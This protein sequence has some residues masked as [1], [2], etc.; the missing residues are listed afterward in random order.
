MTGEDG[1]AVLQRIVKVLLI[2]PFDEDHRDL[3]E[4]LRHSN[5]QQY[6]ARTQVEACEFLRENVTPG[7]YLRERTAGRYLAECLV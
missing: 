2:S 3:R 6:E 7:G 1:P 5:W 4:I